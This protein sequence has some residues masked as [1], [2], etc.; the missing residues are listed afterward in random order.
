MEKD[1]KLSILWLSVILFNILVYLLVVGLDVYYGGTRVLDVLF[2]PWSFESEYLIVLGVSII[3]TVIAVCNSRWNSKWK[4]IFGYGIPVLLLIF[5]SYMGISDY[6]CNPPSCQLPFPGHL[7]PLGFI[8][9]IVPIVYGSFYIVGVYFSGGFTR[10]IRSLILIESLL[11]TGTII[12]LAYFMSLD[13]SLSYLRG[14]KN[15]ELSEI[16]KIC[17]KFPDRDRRSFCFFEANRIYPL[18]DTNTCSSLSMLER[19]RI[20]CY[21]RNG[22]PQPLK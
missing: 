9:A 10:F 16:I 18:M 21:E 12:F 5:I 13:S 4:N 6:T 20:A 8:F 1:K 15:V 11:I 7:W 22:F 14:A 2:S 3:T 17:D 19:S